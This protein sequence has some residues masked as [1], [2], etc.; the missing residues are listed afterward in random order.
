MSVP[1]VTYVTR[2]VLICLLDYIQAAQTHD[3]RSIMI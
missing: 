2:A 1:V 3:E